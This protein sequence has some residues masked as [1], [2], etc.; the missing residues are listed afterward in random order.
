M[1][2]KDLQQSVAVGDIRLELFNRDYVDGITSMLLGWCVARAARAAAL[3][4]ALGCEGVG[5]QGR[6]VW[7][8]QLF[9]TV[10]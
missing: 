5:A 1:P 3:R 9:L 2:P 4:G 7:G 6:A 8:R 10:A